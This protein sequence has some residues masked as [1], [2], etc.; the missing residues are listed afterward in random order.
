MLPTEF[1]I[2]RFYIVA[3]PLQIMNAH[4]LEMLHAKFEVSRSHRLGARGD[5][6][7]L[8]PPSLLLL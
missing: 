1:E 2:S 3:E 7:K 4:R 5:Y 6:P 8:A